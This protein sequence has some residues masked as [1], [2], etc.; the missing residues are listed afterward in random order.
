MFGEQAPQGVITIETVVAYILDE[1]NMSE[2]YAEM[3]ERVANF[4][5]RGF[6]DMNMFHLTNIQVE[7]LKVGQDNTVNLPD[8]YIDYRKIGIEVNG[9]VWTLTLND[10]IALPRAMKC[11]EDI[12]KVISSPNPSQF[13]LNFGYYFPDHVRNGRYIGGLY[14]VGGG[15][16]LAYCRIDKERRQ[17]VLDGRVPKCEVVLEYVST[18][19]SMSRQTII[20]RIALEPLIAFG[21]WKMTPFDRIGQKEAAKN[22][23]IMEVE[24]MRALENAMTADEFRDVLYSSFYAAPKR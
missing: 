21:I 2:R 9:R 7:Y 22:D 4:V 3:A 16:N 23:Y 14:G 15:F 11:G 17:I 5:I 6:T 24:K 19:V 12:R 8:D 18:G 13:G 10:N 20:P 1:L